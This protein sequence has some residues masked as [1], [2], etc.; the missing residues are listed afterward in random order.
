MKIVEKPIG[1]GKDSKLSNIV[2]KMKLS[3]KYDMK[4]SVRNQKKIDHCRSNSRI[5]LKDYLYMV[6]TTSKQ[7]RSN[8]Y[9][10]INAPIREGV[11]NQVKSE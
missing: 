2:S 3:E 1:L 6:E 5:K 8:K 4:D 11:L 7:L 10:H 9:E